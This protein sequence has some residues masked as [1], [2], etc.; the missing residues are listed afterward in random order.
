[1]QSAAMGVDAGFD[2]VPR[3]SKGV[4]DRHNWDQFIGF[5]KNH[6]KD[7]TQVEIKPNYILF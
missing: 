2:M 3:L 5:I 4:V 1:L 6:Y 7:D